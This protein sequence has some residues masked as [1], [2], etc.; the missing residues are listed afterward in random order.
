MREYCHNIAVFPQPVPARNP[1]GDCFACAV[2][3]TFQYIYGAQ[4][5]T[6]DQVWEAFQREV[7]Y[8]R[9]GEVCRQVQLENS[10]S[11]YRVALYNLRAL[12]GPFDVQTDFAA[13]GVPPFGHDSGDSMAWCPIVDEGQW[14]HR[15]DAW[16]RAGWYAFA[17]IRMDPNPTGEWVLTEEGPRRVSTDHFV[18]LDGIRSG[19]R[20]V[21]R[22]PGAKSFETQVHVVCSARGGRAYWIDVDTFLREHGA[23]AWW[24]V[25]P[26]ETGDLL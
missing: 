2:T 6:F 11:G 26:G 25:R 3:A 24:L 19:W 7:E 12:V 18:V 9:N 8:V 10:W 22:F 14:G 4:A 15:L 5:P 13:R 1:G 20:A 16:L 23:G 17:C 21:E